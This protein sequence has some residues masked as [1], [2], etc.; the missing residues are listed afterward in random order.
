MGTVVESGARLVELHFDNALAASLHTG[1]KPR[2]RFRL[3]VLRAL[4]ALARDVETKPEYRAIPAV[5]GASLFWAGGT[6]VGLDH[7]PLSPF[8]RWRLARWEQF[9]LAR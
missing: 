2:L 1:G 8:T 6:F 4:P 9:P 7:R 3:E 5:C